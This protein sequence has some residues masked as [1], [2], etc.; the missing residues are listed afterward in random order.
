MLLSAITTLTAVPPLYTAAPN[1]PTLLLRHGRRSWHACAQT[2]TNTIAAAAAT[3]GS[4]AKTHHAQ[5]AAHQRAKRRPSHWAAG[6]SAEPQS[7][8][9]RG[10]RARGPPS[11]KAQRAPSQRAPSQRAAEPEGRR[12]RGPQS[13]RTHAHPRTPTHTRAHLHTRTQRAKPRTHAHSQP[14]PASHQQR[15]P[16]WCRSGP[17]HS[18]VLADGCHAGLAKH[19]GAQ[20]TLGAPPL[21]FWGS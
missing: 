4:R 13:Q 2:N 6:Q 19:R 5:K 1:P 7:R 18:P 3:T 10:R 15:E 14:R 11:Q 12:A 20:G 17:W 9:A 8:R 21:R 16:K